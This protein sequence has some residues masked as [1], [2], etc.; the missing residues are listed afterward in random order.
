M[1][2][3]IKKMVLKQGQ[4]KNDTFFWAVAIGIFLVGTLWVTLGIMGLVV[5]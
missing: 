5:K 3:K 2:K 1:I 4:K